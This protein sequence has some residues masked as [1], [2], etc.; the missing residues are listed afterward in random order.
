[1]KVLLSVS[2]TYPYFGGGVS[3]WAHHLINGLSD[4]EFQVTSIVSNPNITARFPLARNMR[5]TTIPLWGVGRPEEFPGLPSR[6]VRARYRRATRRTFEDEFL[7]SYE[8]VVAQCMRGAPDPRALGLAFAAMARFFRTYDFY[9]T[10]R[11]AAVWNTFV[12]VLTSDPLFGHLSVMDTIGLCRRLE[13]HLRVLTAPVEPADVAHVAVAGIAGVPAVL[14]KIAH[15]APL[16]L[17]EHGVYYRERLLDLINEQGA[18]PQKVFLANFEHAIVRLNYAFADLVTPVCH[19]NSRWEVAMG[20]PIGKVRVIYNGVDTARFSPLSESENAVPTVITV[21]RVD[22]LKDTLNFIE[23]MAYVHRHIPGARGR[24]YGEAADPA[25]RHL[26]ATRMR[27]L[28]LESAVTFEQATQ[29]PEA[30]YRAAAVVV[31]PSLSEGFPFGVIEAMACGKMI[32]ATDVG[33]VHEALEGCGVLVPPR[34][35]KSLGMAIVAALR[36]AARRRECGARAR[37]R[38]VQHYQLRDMLQA[39]RDVYQ[40]LAV[41]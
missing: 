2:G 36:D 30:A 29:E 26:C 24:I 6:S 21:G 32:V 7:A 1:M 22:R 38:A 23:A 13:R 31:S 35:P 10:M 20:V 40:H 5:L 9:G 11:H 41:H 16:L 8:T 17:T 28:G 25:Y 3:V 27:D 39:Y 14:A 34:S 12:R 18:P 19:F 15:G 37:K 4:V 33:G